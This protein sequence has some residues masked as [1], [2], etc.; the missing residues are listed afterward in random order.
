MLFAENPENGVRIHYEVEG[1]GPPL[2][3]QHGTGGSLEH[4][5]ARGYLD[6]Q[7]DRFRLLLIDPRGHRESDQPLEQEAYEL[8]NRVA[9]HRRGDHRGRRADGA[10]LPLLDGRLDRLRRC[11]LHAAAAPLAG[12]RWIRPGTGPV[13]RSLAG[14]ARRSSSPRRP[15]RAPR[16]RERPSPNLS[17][18]CGR[19]SSRR[20][21]ASAAQCRR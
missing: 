6:C 2:V 11:D 7:R 5:R 20:P 15:R 18:Q 3:L 14:A 21:R 9:R 8:R 4:W 1:D 12:D 17:A 13:L 16:R 19:S 10:L